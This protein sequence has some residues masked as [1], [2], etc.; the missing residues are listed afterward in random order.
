MSQVRLSRRNAIR[1]GGPYSLNIRYTV[2]G[3]VESDDPVVMIAG[4]MLAPVS[5]AW[6]TDNTTS[7][8]PA[9]PT[10]P[11]RAKASPFSAN[12]LSGA[13]T[14][15]VKAEGKGEL[16]I[17]GQ[18]NLGM[19]EFMDAYL[20]AHGTDSLTLCIPRQSCLNFSGS[21]LLRFILHLSS[22]V[23]SSFSFVQACMPLSAW[24][25]SVQVWLSSDK[26]AR[27][28]SNEM[29][30]VAEPEILAAEILLSMKYSGKALEETDLRH[31][32]MLRMKVQHRPKASIRQEVTRHAAVALD[33][34]YLPGPL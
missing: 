1:G 24:T 3:T 32:Q 30:D 6:H 17:H 19:E 27:H 14:T 22:Y 28:H 16:D 21:E 12:G 10:T 7:T 15:D 9:S 33:A 13:K 23:A 11:E 26:F 25:H 4:R 29:S 31:W 18:P 34:H 2:T 5:T 8:P 20:P